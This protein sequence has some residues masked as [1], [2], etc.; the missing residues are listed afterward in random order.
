MGYKGQTWCPEHI[1][2]LSMKAK[3]CYRALT[4]EGPKAPS[5]WWEKE[6]LPPISN[7]IFKLKDQMDRS[8]LLGY[9]QELEQYIQK[10]QKME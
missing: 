7:P 8:D 3:G 5:R 10:Y 2:S 4:E 1:N 6:I 9:I